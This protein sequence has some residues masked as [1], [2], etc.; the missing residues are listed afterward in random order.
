MM[1]AVLGGKISKNEKF[2]CGHVYIKSVSNESKIESK[3]MS[4]I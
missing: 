1:R 4:M 2:N 3:S